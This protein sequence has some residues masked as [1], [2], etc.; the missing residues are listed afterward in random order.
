MAQR[1]EIPDY[2]VA[3]ALAMREAG[4]TRRQ[5]GALV[6]ASAR[7]V[8]YWEEHPRGTVTDD[9]LSKERRK[10]QAK[11]WDLV[12][13]SMKVA[14]KKMEGLKVIEAVLVASV[15]QELALELEEVRYEA[16]GRRVS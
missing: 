10:L 16:E 11:V 7:T 12:G 8:R 9:I 3:R 1:Q 14:E 4:A 13:L 5:V 15:A 6:G 2:L